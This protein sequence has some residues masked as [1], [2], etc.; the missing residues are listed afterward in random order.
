M[1]SLLQGHEVVFV[2][3]NRGEDSCWDMFLM[4]YC[5]ELIIANSSFSWWGAFLN[6]NVKT[7][8]VPEPWLRRDCTI[9]IYD[10]QW[11]RIN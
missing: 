9:D 7:V 11:V 10:P 3:G 6:A 4:T 8:C 5:Q 2:D 1:P